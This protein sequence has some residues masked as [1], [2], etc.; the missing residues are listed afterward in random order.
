MAKKPWLARTRP[1]P[2]QVVQVVGVVPGLQPEPVQA[3][4]FS[5]AGTVIRAVQ[6]A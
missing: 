2:P 3:S 5:D 1:A 4:Q 6:P